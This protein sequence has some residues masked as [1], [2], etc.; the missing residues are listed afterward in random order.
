MSTL[1]LYLGID[2]G[3]SSTK[4]VLLDEQGVVHH[5]L[6]AA[7]PERVEDDR[8]VEQDPEGLLDSVVDVFRRAKAWAASQAAVSQAAESQEVVVAG[9]GL[10]VQRSGVLAWN[11]TDGRIR[12]RM[13]TWADTRTLP[14]IQNFGRGV[15]RLSLK[16]G[17][18]TIANF[19]AGKIHQLQR[20]F[21]EPTILV[22]T[23]DTFLLHRLS[24]KKVF[25]TE[26]SMA[27]RTMLYALAERGWSAELCREFGV[28]LGRLAPISASLSHHTDYDG[29]PILALLGD[30]QAA[31]I[32]RMGPSRRGLLNLGTIASLVK[33]TGA[34][35]V[36]KTGLMTSVLLSRELPEGGGRDLRFIVE[37]TS[38]V[39][40]TVLLEPLRRAWCKSSEE[41]NAMCESSF[42][43]APEG[44]AIGYFVNHRAA[45]ATQTESLPN[46]LVCREGATEADR[47][48]A[49]VENVGNIIVRMIE[50][51]MD[52]KLLGETSPPEVDVAGGGSEIDYLLQY[53]ADVSGVTLHRRGAREAG[54]RG[55]ALCALMQAKTVSDPVSFNGEPDEKAYRCERFER[56]KRYQ[57]WLR[58]EQDT[59]RG[60]LPPQAEKS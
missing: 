31:L 9:V 38:P 3:S 47:A 60:T 23:L 11:S 53:I 32:G 4:G 35:P 12:H 36:Q 56:R 51:F 28:D 45:S 8:K 37:A 43:A 29:T 18:P 33:D 20:Q 52:K 27:A 34:E 19:A 54:A 30:Q 26:D 6:Y 50:E 7:V 24:G 39:T 49:V 17:L 14:I 1:N 44:R 46:V 40:G 16:T 2:Q 59:M 21:L 48:R 55:A 13:M 15:E 5:E 58:L 22:G 42:L 57:M 10:A 25:M 41:L